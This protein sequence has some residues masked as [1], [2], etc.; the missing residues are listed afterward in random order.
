M[1]LSDLQNPVPQGQDFGLTA[2]F[3]PAVNF[4]PSLPFFPRGRCFNVGDL[5]LSV[6]VLSGRTCSAWLQEVHSPSLTASGGGTVESC[7]SPQFP[8][9]AFADP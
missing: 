8:A 3:F 5:C 6:R 2:M 9:E 4:H 1:T 7:P